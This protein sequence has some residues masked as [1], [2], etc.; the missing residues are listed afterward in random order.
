[1]GRIFLFGDSFTYNLFNIPKGID[2]SYITEQ[3]MLRYIKLL[4]SEGNSEPLHF[5]DHLKNFGYEVY[6]YGG[7]GLSM[8]S[9]IHY[10]KTLSTFQFKEGDR[11]IVNLTSFSRFNLIDDKGV[12]HTAVCENVGEWTNDLAIK[13]FITD[14]RLNRLY[15]LEN[16]GFIGMQFLDFFKYFLELHKEY[17]PILWSPFPENIKHFEDYKWFVRDISDPI[18]KSIC[19]EYDKIKIW[20][21]TC[22]L[23]YDEHYGRYGNYYNAHIFKAVLESGLDE[24]YLSD[25]DL[26]LKIL[27]IVSTETGFTPLVNLPKI[28][29]TVSGEPEFITLASTHKESIISKFKKLI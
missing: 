20:D 18:F 25:K 23:I 14:Q 26:N 22:N 10:F 12:N 11:I 3:I 21:E 27:D 7:N 29:D 17:K 15:S 19:P 5:S 13:S 1:M 16:R 6:N 28:P 4:T 9:I 8:D 2:E 24:F